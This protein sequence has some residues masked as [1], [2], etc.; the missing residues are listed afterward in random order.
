MNRPGRPRQ[1]LRPGL[2]GAAI[3]A[4]ILAIAGCSS[5]GSSAGSSNSGSSSSIKIGTLESTS[6]VLATYGIPEKQAIELAINQVNAT[7]GIDGHKLVWTFL[8][9]AGDTATG[10][11]MTHQLIQQD[12]VQ[13]IVGGGTSSGIALAMNRLAQGIVATP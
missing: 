12:G 6:G 7:G 8:D 10:V 3:V 4:A 11:S 5:S 1:P 9:P 13:V 2:A